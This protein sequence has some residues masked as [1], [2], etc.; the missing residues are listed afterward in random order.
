MAMSIPTAWMNAMFSTARRW[1]AMAALLLGLLQVT[2]FPPLGWFPVG[3]LALAGLFLLLDEGTPAVGARTGFAFGVGLFGGGTYWLFTAIHGFGHAPVAL[4]LFLM[5]ALVALMSAWYAL[6]GY[7]TRRW[8]CYP[9]RLRWLMVLP[10]GWVLVEWARSRA[11]TGFPWLT[12]GYTQVDTWLAGY[13]PVGGVYLVTLATAVCAGALAALARADRQH[14]P[15][16]V[17]LLV[18][19]VGLGGV[20]VA[21][22]WTHPDGK[23][24]GVA[25]VQGAV[26]QDLKWSPAQ[27]DATLALYRDL[28]KP[29][30]GTPLVVWPEA[31]LPVLAEEATPFLREQWSAASS[32]GSALLMGLL[33]YDLKSGSVRNGLLVLDTQR[34]P[35]WYFKR[36]LV[37]F[38]EYFPVPA[39]VREWMRLSSLAFVDLQPGMEGQPVPVAQGL[40]LAAT[41]CYEDAYGSDQLAPLTQAK[42]L[43]NV[44]NN[45]WY[46]DSSA[47][48][49]HLQ[50]SRMRAVEAGR[51]LVRATSN[52]ISVIV[53]PKGEV[54]ARAPQF[55]PV[56]LRGEVV[57]YTGLTPY[58]WLG[59]DWTVLLLAAAG[60]LA[61]VWHRPRT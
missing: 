60:V 19:V 11:F 43:V 36:H 23:P 32:Q 4:A 51:Y 41:I 25:I 3:V 7:V 37:P 33:S 1:P 54:L 38:G 42:L 56:V 53:G 9:G 16:P 52:G 48:H 58:A 14:W 47:S 5:A 22:P 46:G 12:L 18:G 40:P 21:V 17:G 55:Q 45:A 31:A 26:P 30:W 29:V 10:G 24:I 20:L 49:Q 50:I 44:T 59:G 15:W 35:Q 8:F 27:R 6:L 13:A 34:A 2:A 57:P 28:S 61:G 39:K